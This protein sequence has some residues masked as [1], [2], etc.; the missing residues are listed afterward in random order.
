MVTIICCRDAGNF[1]F[2]DINDFTKMLDSYSVVPHDPGCM[3]VMSESI[4]LY[5]D[6]SR[7][8]RSVHQLDCGTLPPRSRSGNNSLCLSKGMWWDMCFVKEQN[9]NMIIVASSKTNGIEAYNIDTGSL[10]WKGQ[11]RGLQKCGVTSDGH[12]HIYVCDQAPANR[13]IHM[14]SAADGKYQ[15]CLIGEGEQGLG[16]PLWVVWSEPT[17]SL[18]VTHGKGDKRFF[19]V[20]YIQVQDIDSK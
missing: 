1:E 16:V 2:Y 19:S 4:V 12:G 20:I 11:R 9:K 7:N 10:E 5:M 17:S 8:P 18:I 3:C 15:G 14:F 13:C 6:W